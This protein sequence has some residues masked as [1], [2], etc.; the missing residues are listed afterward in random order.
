[1]IDETNRLYPPITA[2]SRTAIGSDELAGEPIK[3]GTM[4][5]IAPYVPPSSGAVDETQFRIPAVFR[6]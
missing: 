2:M 1:V 4:I 6:R 3:P 5:V